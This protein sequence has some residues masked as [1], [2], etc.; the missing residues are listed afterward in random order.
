MKFATVIGAL[1]VSSEIVISP[2]TAPEISRVTFG[3]A[4]T[5]RPAVKIRHIKAIVILF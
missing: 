1:S 3:G 2:V 5:Q 4:P